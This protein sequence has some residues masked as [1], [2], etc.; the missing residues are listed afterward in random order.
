M[1]RTSGRCAKDQPFLLGATNNFIVAF[2][3]CTWAASVCAAQPAPANPIQHV[4]FIV[5]E[6]RSFNNYF[7][8]FPGAV[9]ASWGPLSNGTY[10]PLGRTPDQTPHNIGHDWFS[11]IEVYDDG[12]MD[13]F[14][15][16]YGGNIE[17]DYLAYTQ[18][19]PQDIPNYWTYAQDF[20]LADHMFS[21]LH[22]PSLPNHF[23]TIAAQSNSIISVPLQHPGSISKSW[24]CDSDTPLQV[25]QLQPDGS[26]TLIPPCFDVETLGDVLD[27]ANVDWR[28]YSSVY[29]VPGYQWNVYNNISHIRYGADW[30]TKMADEKQF[31]SDALNG[32]LPAVTWMTPPN[33]ETEH[34]PKPTCGGENW[35]VD[36]INSIMQGPQWNSTAIFLTWDDFGGF[37]DP[38]KPPQVDTF[39]L[40]PRVPLLIISPYAK[41]GTVVHTQYEFSSVL[42][43]IEELYGLPSLTERDANANDMMDAFDFTQKPLSPVVL[44]KRSCPIVDTETQFGEQLVGSQTTNVVTIFNTSQSSVNVSSMTVA[45]GNGNFTVEHCTGFNIHAGHHCDFNVKFTPTKLGPASATITLADN[46]PGS[47]QVITATGIG[48]ALSA[49]NMTHQ[50]YSVGMGTLLFGTSQLIG[51]AGHRSFNLINTGTAAI[52]INSI[53]MIGSDFV[54]TNA[55]VGTLAP[56]AQCNIAVTFTPSVMGPRW[57]QINIADSD[58]GSPH[59]VRVMGTG[60]L[61]GQAAV[62][63]K[64]E[65]PTHHDFD[66]DKY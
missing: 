46:Y 60:L 21:S 4:V 50:M 55:C 34:P 33:D 51:K 12:K 27:A 37:Y 18:M 65:Q 44:S 53:R 16:N 47:P 10:I 52:K 24:G 66:D 15:I 11:A 38:V 43:F 20:V 19:Q 30:T 1:T 48:S 9:G 59:M 3:L 17:G 31:D 64:E 35:T 29:G 41:A 58:P 7:G 2:L 13:R 54:Q 5:K 62:T 8:L 22:G 14:D 57:G 28:Y 23:Y 25:Q 56:Q 40:G 63:I 39:G 42:K 26:I 45:G 36:R 6:N 61:P 49:T 32:K